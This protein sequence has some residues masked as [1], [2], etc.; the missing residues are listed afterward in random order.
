M[1]TS[2][3]SMLMLALLLT[4][5]GTVRPTLSQDSTKVEVRTE[6]VTV[7]DTAYVELP[8]I[9]EKVA[10]LDTASTLENKFARSEAIVSAGILSHSLETKPIQLPVQVE[11]KIVYK[12]SLV[13][14]DRVQTQM[15]E[16]EKKLTG[17]QQA[18][19]RVGGFCFFLLIIIAIYFLISQF[20]NLN[21]L[22]L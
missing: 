18:K 7:H 3:I 22:K 21:L 11:T 1:K 6:T 15:V 12:D 17:W 16:V 14:R 4:A 19:L 8:L 20:I 2:I 10:T 5:C 13:F 9:I